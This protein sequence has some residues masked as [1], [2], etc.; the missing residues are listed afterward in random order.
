VAAFG[1]PM[2]ATTR[3]LQKFLGHWQMTDWLDFDSSAFGSFPD[4]DDEGATSGG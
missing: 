3:G 4:M 2:D 1:S